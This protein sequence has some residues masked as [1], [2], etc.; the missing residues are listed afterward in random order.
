MILTSS[1][2]FL[3]PSPKFKHAD[4]DVSKDSKSMKEKT[5]VVIETINH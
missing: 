5:D 2:A 4:A 1:L 3:M